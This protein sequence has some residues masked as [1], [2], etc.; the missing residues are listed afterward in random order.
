M[1]NKTV[2][3][4]TLGKSPQIITE[5]LWAI[6]QD[7]KLEW[8]NEIKIIT[9]QQCADIAKKALLPGGDT[10]EGKLAELYKD[11]G[12]QNGPTLTDK[13]FLLISDKTDFDKFI[14]AENEI[15]DF[16]MSK[17]KDLT[18]DSSVAIHANYTGGI[19]SMSTVLCRAMDFYGRPFDLLSCIFVTPDFQQCKEFYYPKDQNITLHRGTKNEMKANAK[20]ANITLRK[21]SPIPLKYMRQL[22]SG[23]ADLNRFSFLKVLLFLKISQSPNTINLTFHYN[24]KKSHISVSTPEYEFCEKIQLPTGIFAFYAMTAKAYINNK[25]IIRAKI[26][27][28]QLK[29]MLADEI[30][31]MYPKTLSEKSDP[32]EL[33]TRAGLIPTLGFDESNY[34]TYLGNLRKNLEKDVSSL[35]SNIISPSL[36]DGKQGNA[37]ILKIPK[38]NINFHYERSA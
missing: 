19:K 20:D 3:L 8:P 32:F 33:L 5:T 11:L 21:T 10:E 31:L 6:H 24:E 17:V 14:E 28:I 35:I 12:I 16:I 38:E 13:S 2:L 30:R 23:L 37:Y 25:P 15:E 36:E 18:N 29:D 9:N 7:E 1:H 22:K 4:F 34:N 26:D 27:P